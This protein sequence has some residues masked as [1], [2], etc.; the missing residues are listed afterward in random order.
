MKKILLALTIVCL[1]VQL[2]VMAADPDPTIPPQK[3]WCKTAK[4]PRQDNISPSH[5]I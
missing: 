3:K 2:D 1:I 4:W 5:K